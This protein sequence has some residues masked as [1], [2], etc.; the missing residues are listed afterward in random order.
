MKLTNLILTVVAPLVALNNIYGWGLRFLEV[1]MG[2]YD[3]R[4][5]DVS[6][7]RKHRHK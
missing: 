3:P 6:V 4:N 2:T 5:W 1:R 7:T